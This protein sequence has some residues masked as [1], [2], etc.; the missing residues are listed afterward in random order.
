MKFRPIR[1]MLRELR[2]KRIR[3]ER[4]QQVTAKVIIIELNGKRGL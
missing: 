1:N 4:S 2:Q 3:K